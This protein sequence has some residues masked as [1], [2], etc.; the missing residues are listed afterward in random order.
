MYK[1]V[2]VKYL[3]II[4]ILIKKAVAADQTLAM[5]AT[6]F[7]RASAGRKAGYKFSLRFSNGRLENTVIT[8]PVAKDLT[9]TLLQDEVIKEHF[10]QS[11]FLI[12]MTT[13]FQLLLKATPKELV[14][15]ESLLEEVQAD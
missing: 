3:P 15:E 8:S 10:K 2:W 13:K 4:R 14:E 12:E 5:N 7:E 1:H 9:E 6:D 11:N